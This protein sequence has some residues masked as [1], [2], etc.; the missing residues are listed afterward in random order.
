MARD[1]V[2]SF[3][4]DVGN[5]R[6]WSAAING[7]A[8]SASESMQRANRAILSSSVSGGVQGSLSDF[9][10]NPVPGNYATNIKVVAD[11]IDNVFRHSATIVNTFVQDYEVAID[12]V[13]RQVSVKPL[14]G[15]A[16]IADVNRAT[17]AVEEYIA[18][19]RQMAP[20]NAEILRIKEEARTGQAALTQDL[21]AT[22]DAIK[23]EQ[24][25]L[26]RKT[27]SVTNTTKS[28]AL[29]EFKPAAPDV[30]IATTP[31]TLKQIEQAIDAQKRLRADLITNAR[32]LFATRGVGATF[33]EGEKNPYQ[34]ILDAQKKFEEV[35][36]QYGTTDYATAIANAR[37][38]K[39]SP[40]KVGVITKTYNALQAEIV[41]GQAKLDATI[42]N[43]ESAHTN[44][45]ASYE[46]GISAIRTTIEN[47]PVLVEQRGKIEALKHLANTEI[48]AAIEG[49][50]TSEKEALERL[51][52]TTSLTVP[53][54]ET[55]LPVT[56]NPAEQIR[57]AEEAVTKQTVP[58]TF[59]R[60]LQNREVAGVLTQAGL[61]GGA[62]IGSLDFAKNFELQKA[63]LKNV[64]T[65][66]TTGVTNLR[67]EFGQLDAT[68]GKLVEGS[69]R[70]FS[71]RLDSAGN[72]IDKI[73]R[74]VQA[75]GEQDLKNLGFPVS[76]LDEAQKKIAQLANQTT[77]S[78]NQIVTGYKAVRDAVGQ[79]WKVEPIFGEDVTQNAK[80]TLANVSRYIESAKQAGGTTGEAI[81]NIEKDAA[82]KQAAVLNRMELNAKAMSQIQ[83]ELITSRQTIREGATYTPRGGLV[84]PAEGAFLSDIQQ[85]IV[86]LQ[87]ASQS[88]VNAFRAQIDRLYA[89]QGRAALPQIAQINQQIIAEGNSLRAQVTPLQARVDAINAVWMQLAEGPKRALVALEAQ[90]K[91][92]GAELATIAADSQAAVQGV[93]FNT[94]GQPI[95]SVTPRTPLT[96]AGLDVQRRLANEVVPAD[97][98]AL[99]QQSPQLQKVLLRSG[100]GGGAPLNSVAFFENFQKQGAQVGQVIED[101]STRT[102][103][104]SVQFGKLS[105]DGELVAGS[106]KRFNAT[107][108][109]G[110]NI[111]S[112]YRGRLSGLSGAFGQT[113]RDF[114][115]VVEWTVA[116]TAVFGT[117]GLAIRSVSG[118]NQLNAN[119]ER[120]AITAQLSDREAQDAF[121]GLAKVAYD[122][123]TPL[124]E[125]VKAADDIALATRKAGQ[126]TQ[127]WQQNIESLTQ[128][129]GILTNIAGIDTVKATDLLT[130]AFKQLDIAPNA[131]IGL[132]NKVTAA[133]GGQSN[134]IADIIQAVGSISEAG[135]AASLSIDDMIGSVQVLSQVTSKTP[136]DVATAF[137]NLFGAINSPAS[138][139]TLKE[140]GIQVRDSAGNLRPFLTIYQEVADAIQQGI[141]PAGRV[142]D[143]LRAI[144]GG[145]RRAPDAAAFLGN[146]DKIQEAIAR[147]TVASNEALL[148][149]ARLLDTNSAKITQLGIAFDTAIFQKFG[150]TISQTI[151][152]IV[153][154]LTNLLNAFNKIPT[155]VL[156]TIAGLGALFVAIKLG[157]TIGLSFMRTLQG[158]A[159]GL[160]D[161]VPA[162][163]KA[164]VGLKGVAEAEQ[165]T[166]G[167]GGAPFSAA[168]LGR[169]GVIAGVG[170]AAGG[171]AS[172]LSSGG[173]INPI[174]TL[175]GVASGAGLALSLG[176]FPEFGLPL[177]LGG[178]I[179]PQ[180]LHAVGIGNNTV[181]NPQAQEQTS[182]AN[183]QEFLDAAKSYQEA[184][185]SVQNLTT[186]QGAL[187]DQLK[188]TA[189]TSKSTAAEIQQNNAVYQQYLQTTQELAAAHDQLSQAQKAL[190]ETTPDIASKF[191]LDIEAAKA[192]LL[193]VDQLNKLIADVTSARLQQVYPEFVPLEQ[194]QNQQGQP[195][196][197]PANFNAPPLPIEGPTTLTQQEPTRSQ[198]VIVGGVG[199]VTRD[200]PGA[201]K[202]LDLTTYLKQLKD[203]N[204]VQGL[205]NVATQKN[206]FA[207]NLNLQTIDMVVAALRDM[208]DAVGATTDEGKNLLQVANELQTKGSIQQQAA[209]YVAGQQL[210][211]QALVETGQLPSSGPKSFDTA[212]ANLNLYQRLAAEHQATQ[213]QTYDEYLHANVPN[214]TYRAQERASS[215]LLDKQ[216]NIKPTLIQGS[217][218]EDIVKSL[219]EY[220][221]LVEAGVKLTFDDKVA[222]V[223]ATGAQVAYTKAKRDTNQVLVDAESL[224]KSYIANLASLGQD[225]ASL[226][227]QVKNGQITKKQ[228][229]DLMGQTNGLINLNN[230]LSSTFKNI[231]VE[232]LREIERS[233][234]Q[235]HGFEDAAT[236]TGDEFIKRLIAMS[237]QAG[238][239][240]DQIDSV[241]LA[242]LNMAG[243]LDALPE[244]KRITIEIDT[245]N[246]QIDKLGSSSST[247]REKSLLQKLADAQAQYD[248]LLK[249][250]TDKLKTTYSSGTIDTSGKGTKATLN[251]SSLDIPQEIIDS[252]MM[253]QLVAKAEAQA[254]ALQ[255]KI[256][257]E[258]KA[259]SNDVVA[260]LNGIKL[261]ENVRG[262][263]E[264]Y[265]RKALDNLAAEIK[266]Q[267]DLMTK[268]DMIS[269]IRIGSGSF[270]AIANVPMNSQ[271]GVSLG[272]PQ[273]PININLNINGQVLTPAQM[274]AIAQRIIAGIKLRA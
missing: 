83:N 4:G 241:T 207:W 182:V 105:R 160:L 262:T 244:F 101:I 142:Q 10:K 238:L 58:A 116:T 119:L 42:A 258:D 196:I 94:A 249:K 201:I 76:N 97:F 274:D 139:K 193:S 135:K 235:I 220:N 145:P 209:A 110:G 218:V 163:L 106:T 25:V 177:M 183:T 171:A 117:L 266:K 203:A 133:A 206:G 36:G 216:G 56:I 153:T 205:I 90:G 115:K 167:L 127:E 204:D 245:I 12:K 254:K 208:A 57:Q 89:T 175:G 226:D 96:P 13:T 6:E 162:S 41:N 259:A 273:G 221:K 156:S 24:Q 267:N 44:T 69:M 33:E 243:A 8:A 43:I 32:T 240:R 87:T 219:P 180:L 7:A 257:G 222:L 52:T 212:Q 190:G 166:L 70:D 148:A 126:S 169:F 165:L 144:S 92:M 155:S 164:S 38:A 214:E 225:R 65:D 223:E 28:P 188:R 5:L 75:F 250:Y 195:V 85:S 172:V 78:S 170:A 53:H 178:T 102:K 27:V 122:T 118:I 174:D 123:A 49:I 269:R 251:V 60:Y 141:I 80:T 125:I 48:P 149:N 51:R 184:S 213:A 132:L 111:I 200:V 124:N 84:N 74:K 246:N 61:G 198:T 232:R 113:I 242:V 272:G 194:T 247:G 270:A 256:P 30:G 46:G 15:E 255:H 45:L 93:L 146:I 210:R 229:S 129:V 197:P 54:P 109:E 11:A 64:T 50:G 261:F 154:A 95:S 31:M 19:T 88:R 81:A 271:T 186:R 86:N 18:A 140:F 264:E 187:I 136:A 73:G 217:Q 68:T 104:V 161:L 176:G 173:Q 211:L 134:A 79:P 236:L 202:Q 159:L 191:K 179:A 263:K 59:Q 66:L 253:A 21:L 3:Y 128:A 23:T 114:S 168:K 1:F 112:T 91:L 39:V 98:Q 82:T 230:K 143:V 224:Q 138:I 9:F 268:A 189:V 35:A 260:L 99:L 130:A 55:G 252:G 20:L 151:D 72:V 227:Q 157:T 67:G 239:N 108:D 231:S 107:L 150:P 63:Q 77:A 47:D 71:I 192:G 62:P 29:E 147:S 199:P 158:I 2:V 26:A 137:K 37:A 131:V 248:A 234:V 17:G 22:Q 121:R 185:L 103:Q 40:A 152:T 14:F 120:F 34:G 100:L 181:Q 233:F 215:S 228:Y 265:L 16:Y 237:K